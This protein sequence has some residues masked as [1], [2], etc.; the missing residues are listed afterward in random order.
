M[1]LKIKNIKFNVDNVAF[2]QLHDTEILVV[3]N[4]SGEGKGPYLLSF[5]PGKVFDGDDIQKLKEQIEKL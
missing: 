5:K 1:F 3:F 4:F 2:F